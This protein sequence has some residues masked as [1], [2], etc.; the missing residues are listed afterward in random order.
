[1]PS[2]AVMNFLARVAFSALAIWVTSL[3][4][5]NVALASDG[6]AFGTI[7]SAL[8][9]GLVLTLVNTL[10]RPVVKFFSLPMYFLTFGLFSFVVNALM[11]WLTS[12]ISASFNIGGLYLARGIGSVIWAALVLSLVQ[13]VIGWFT[14]GVRNSRTAGVS[15]GSR[16]SRASGAYAGPD[17]RGE[18]R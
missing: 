1:M 15:G 4:T 14:P 8:L 13:T 7:I 2:F 17:N 10:I 18:L 5:R 9:V 12:W 6:T 16:T 11:L 3:L